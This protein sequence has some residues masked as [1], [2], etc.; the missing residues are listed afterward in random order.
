VASPAKSALASVPPGPGL[1]CP[2]CAGEALFC[3]GAR[4]RN[5]RVS[6]VVFDYHRCS[7]CG[8]I[9]LSH[10]PGDLDAYYPAEYYQLPESIERLAYLAG[11]ESFKLDL[12]RPFQAGGDLLEIGPG[13]GSFA[14]AAKLAGYAV[15]VVEMDARC[16]EYLKE[17]V[18]V[19]VHQPKPTG[20]LPVGLKT[21]DVVALWHVVEHLADFQPM[22]V[23]LAERVRPGGILALATPNPDAW[24]FRVMKASWP[25]VD[26]PRHL[27]LIPAQVTIDIFR[28]LGFE[29][30]TETTGDPG[31]LSWNR[32]GWQRLLANA[33]PPSRVLRLAA[34]VAGNMIGGVLAPIENRPL[35]GAAYTLLLR[36]SPIE[37]DPLEKVQTGTINRMR[38]EP[39]STPNA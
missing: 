34:A 36:K 2:V 23:E 14:Y 20:A 25:H 17:V 6:R 1:R 18:G 5:Q 39:V 27:Q 21:Y 7:R 19:S 33:L 28:P 38:S 9:F 26:A 16:R 30:V 11:R 35:N 22:L 10:V 8:V 37:N 3:F 13:W 31:G 15:T 4:D 12:L 32:F 29:P 24:Q